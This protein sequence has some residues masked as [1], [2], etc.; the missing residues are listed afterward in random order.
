[1]FSS[2]VK[3]NKLIGVSTGSLT[4]SCG[5]LAIDDWENALSGA[6]VDRG[7]TC[8]LSGRRALR[9]I[10]YGVYGGLNG[11]KGTVAELSLLDRSS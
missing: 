7:L 1:M 3:L 9:S 2:S 6:E 8:D 11:T 10:L 5:T 4:T